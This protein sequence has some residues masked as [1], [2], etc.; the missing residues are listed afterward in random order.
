MPP[1]N[2]WG[3]ALRFGVPRKSMRL[4]VQKM[5]DGVWVTTANA[6]SL[7]AAERHALAV[8]GEVQALDKDGTVVEV[9][10]VP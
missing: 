3:N 2:N 4:T 10:S 6:D 1:P 5:V 9:W 8:G 7:E